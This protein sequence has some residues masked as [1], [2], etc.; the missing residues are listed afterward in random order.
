[1]GRKG[2]NKNRLQLTGEYLRYGET[3]ERAIYT[4]VKIFKF[5]NCA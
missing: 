5:K 4:K 2:K 3:T 1:M